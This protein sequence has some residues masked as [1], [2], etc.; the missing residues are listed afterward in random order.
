MDKIISVYVSLLFPSQQKS[1][2]RTQVRFML[3]IIKINNI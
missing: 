1:I 3:S 2:E